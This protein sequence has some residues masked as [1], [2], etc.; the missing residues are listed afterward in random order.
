MRTKVLI[1]PSLKKSANHTV[2]C[3]KCWVG[4]SA[5]LQQP[6]AASTTLW[7]RS[8]WRIAAYAR[9]LGKLAALGWVFHANRNVLACRQYR[10]DLDDSDCNIQKHLA[11]T[12]FK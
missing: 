10:S 7:T 1:Q 11:S 2:Y 5:R 8:S 12:L 9:F 6:R 4:Y 3:S